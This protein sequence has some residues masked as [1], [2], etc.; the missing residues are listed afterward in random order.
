MHKSSSKKLMRRNHG[1]VSEANLGHHSERMD[2]LVMRLQE[3][4]H[5]A[6]EDEDRE[7]AQFLELLLEYVDQPREMT[8]IFRRFQRTK[9][10]MFARLQQRL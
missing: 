3:L 8:R 1:Q 7:M 9:P 10:N 5:Q 2:N 6:D 4:V